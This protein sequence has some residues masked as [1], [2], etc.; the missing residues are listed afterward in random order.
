VPESRWK[1]GDEVG[2]LVVAFN[3]MLEELEAQARRVAEH[4]ADLENKVAARTA[5][6][7][8]AL[9]RAQAATHAKAEFLANMSHEIRTPMNGVIGMLDLL[10]LERLAPEARNMLDTARGSADALLGL[11][12]DVL[13][14]SKIDAGKLTLEKIDFEL[15]PLAEE[16]AT[17]FTRQ[18]TP[19]ASKWRA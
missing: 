14:F 17:L 5:E 13:D 9:N 12:N 8:D 3:G 19:R 15:R 1:A 4:Q 18:P 7:V 6:L 16:V 10:H 11:L 2:Q